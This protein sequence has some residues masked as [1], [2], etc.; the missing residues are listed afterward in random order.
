MKE[1]H[2]NNTRLMT[3]TFLKSLHLELPGNQATVICRELPADGLDLDTSLPLRLC[4]NPGKKESRSRVCPE[5][6][7]L[8]HANLP[9]IGFDPGRFGSFKMT[10]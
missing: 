7:S 1:K 8:A 10:R 4:S 6:S 9:L 3:N 5:P 2:Y